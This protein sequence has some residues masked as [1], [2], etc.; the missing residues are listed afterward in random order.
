MWWRSVYLKTLREGRVAVVG[1]GVGM[2]LMLFAVQVSVGSVL[3]GS[4][5]RQALVG[6]T[7]SFQWAADP[8]AVTTVGGYATWKLGFTVL[9][10]AVWPLIASSRALRGAE[11]RGVM[12]VLLSVPRGRL[13][14]ALETVAAIWTSLLAM[15]LIASLVGYAGG[16]MA[17]AGYT[18]ADALAFG[19]NLAL[20]TGLF[21]SLALLISQFTQQARTA[22]GATGGILFVAI[23][24]DMVHRVLPGASWLSALSPVY[25]Y[26][27]SKPLVPAFGSD[28]WAMVLLAALAGV[29]GAAAI[30]LFVRRDIG[31]GVGRGARA[32][33]GSRRGARAATRGPVLPRRAWSL[34]SVYARGLA[35]VV[36]P[37]LWWTL[38]IAGFAA[39]TMLATD[40][41]SAQL[42]QLLADAPTMRL[43]L[44]AL[45]GGAARTDE[46]LLGALFVLLPL[47]IMIFAVTQAGRWASDEDDGRQDLILATP[48]P[49]HRVLVAR[50][51]AVATAGVFIALVTL[52]V[53][54]ATADAI[55]LSVSTGH[56]AAAVLSIVPQA[57]LMAALGFLFAGWLGPALESGLLSFLLA[58][59]FFVSFV[60]P[61]LGWSPDVQRLSPFY[62]YGTPLLDGVSL[63]GLLVVLGVA[64][65]ALVGASWRFRRKDI[66]R[67]LG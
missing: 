31:R 53:A 1:W 57:L 63:R 35:G 21:G 18:L 10:L 44:A 49:R 61:E 26:N 17:H 43:M 7:Q 6:I 34:R 47:L 45:G 52:A 67:S 24:L 39:F 5:A 2:G 59:W 55:G 12:D 56:L 22:A 48:Q 9:V 30:A 19:L 16:R 66:G 54:V 11:E 25:Y 51:A 64:A 3:S 36:A 15:A 60:G 14:V 62:Y 20:V 42:E 40:R 13:R 4:G 58:A 33:R 28:P 50:Y 38:A 46:A 32:S 8:V 27:R 37:T 29:T 23:V 41:L 65:A